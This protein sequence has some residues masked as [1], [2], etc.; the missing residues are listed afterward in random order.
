[1]KSLGKHLIVELYDCDFDLINDV[2]QVE[3]ILV[4]AVA[5]SKAT[6]VQPVFHQFSP[7]GVSG[8]V[9]IAESHFTIHTWP[10]Y[11][12]CALDIFTCGEL[13][14]SD[15]S[16]AYLQ[17]AFKAGSRSVMEIKRGVLNL[18]ADRLRHKP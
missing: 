2:S 12:Y 6:I 10:E 11:G 18:P 9:V 3:K 16:L 1:M 5:I 13:I 7:H 4:E 8:V 17:K 14:D 15:A